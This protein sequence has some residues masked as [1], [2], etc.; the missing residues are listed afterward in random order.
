MNTRRINSELV[1]L[2]SVAKSMAD[3]VSDQQPGEN[4]RV[5]FAPKPNDPCLTSFSVRKVPMDRL[6][7][8][9]GDLH[10]KLADNQIGILLDT[11]TMKAVPG[12][13]KENSLKK[14]L[15]LN[16]AFSTFTRDAIMKRVDVLCPNDRYYDIHVLTEAQ[17]GQPSILDSVEA[18]LEALKFEDTC[19]DE[20]R[21]P[22]ERRT[23]KRTP[24]VTLDQIKSAL[25][26]F[27]IADA[28]AALLPVLGHVAP[29]SPKKSRKSRKSEEE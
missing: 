29:S 18:D 3:L 24:L 27:D 4:S 28:S 20:V 26:Q 14:T 12:N 11:A 21:R 17:D 8:F 19:E 16:F 9:L 7:G 6:V 2:R 10:Q 15:F 25:E 1:V 23:F 13:P 22:G 5:T